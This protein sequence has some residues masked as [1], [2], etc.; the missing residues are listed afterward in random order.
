MDNLRA[1]ARA[2]VACDNVCE[3]HS[4]F[5]AACSTR[6][7]GALCCILEVTLSTYSEAVS[8]RASHTLLGEVAAQPLWSS[9]EKPSQR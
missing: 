7:G 1:V 2:P 5:S 8:T 6:V 9:L 4:T 3:T